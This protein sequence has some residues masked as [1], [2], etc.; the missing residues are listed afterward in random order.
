[1]GRIILA[2]VACIS[3]AAVGVTMLNPLKVTEL[4]LKMLAVGL[5]VWKAEVF[6]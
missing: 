2:R 4:W 5:W 3:L 1:V 6:S